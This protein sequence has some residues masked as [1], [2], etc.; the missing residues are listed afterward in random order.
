MGSGWAISGIVF[1]FLLLAGLRPAFG[2]PSPQITE[3]KALSG[4]FSAAAISDD[5]RL[6]LTGEDDGVVS[7]RSVSTGA[8][9][10]EYEGHSRGVLAVALLPG[11]KRAVTCGDD[12][13]VIVWDLATGQCVRQMSTGDSIPLVMACNPGGSLAATGCNDGQIIIWS[14]ASGRRA[15]TLRRPASLCGILFSPDGRLLAAGCSDGHVILWNTADWSERHV[16]PSADSASVGALAFSA[17]S[18]LL[19][20]GN[21]SGAGFVWNTADGSQYSAF[22]GYSHPEASPAPPVAPVFPGSAITPDNR[23][24]IVYLC[25]NRDATRLLVSIQDQSPRIWEAKTGSLLGTAD[26]FGDKRFYVARYGFTF[27]TAVITPS[28]DYIVTMGTGPDNENLAEVW[29]LS[30]TP[31]PPQQ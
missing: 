17:D 14:L 5:G 9:V 22:A 30:F 10:H 29:R 18:R 1:G 31:S 8:T 13:L 4:N 3:F 23:S 27:A 16:F 11:G 2:E 24:A 15:A 6:L 25:F 20:T 26:W 7:L 21:Q 28:R 19:A 12:N